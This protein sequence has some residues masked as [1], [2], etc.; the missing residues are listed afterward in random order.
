MKAAVAPLTGVTVSSPIEG[1][2]TRVAVAEGAVVKP[3]DVIA[4]LTNPVVDRDIAY[5]RAAVI[6]AES[7]MR[8]GRPA[9][10]TKPVSDEGERAAATILA[11]RQQKVD[12]LR[13]LLASGDVSKQ[14]VQDAEAELAAARRDWLAEKERRSDT[15]P[16]APGV[17]RALLQ[18][19]LDRARA[20]LVVAEHRQSALRIVA[21][22]AGSIARLRVHEGDDI[23][24]RDAVA[25]IVETSSVRV[26]AA[27]APELLRYVKVGQAVDVKLMTIPPRRFRETIVR[28]D[29][30][31]AGG[32]PTI[33]VNVPNPDRM[34]QAGTPAVIT[35][36]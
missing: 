5:A 23:Y 15:P 34:L 26:E 33:A 16:P 31:G 12:R 22:S 24:T 2:V 11:A 3:G 32:G 27:I 10:A 14:D 18:A 35:I 25:E 17:D 9:Q 4:E 21:P 30:P 7:R 6:S 36:Q 19:E 20:D 8:G 13:R 28:V 1:R 29:Q